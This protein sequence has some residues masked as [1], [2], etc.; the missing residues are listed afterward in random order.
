M[1]FSLYP[2]KIVLD[3]AHSTANL[4]WTHGF[5]VHKEHTALTEPMTTLAATSR[6]NIWTRPPTRIALLPTLATRQL[7]INQTPDRP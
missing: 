3:H 7:V 4:P 2:K 6:T 1:F 5:Q